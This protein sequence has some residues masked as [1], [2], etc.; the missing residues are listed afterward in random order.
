MDFRW[1]LTVWEICWKC[2]W[3]YLLF[4][5]LK[6]MNTQHLCSRLPQPLSL[7]GQDCWWRFPASSWRKICEFIMILWVLPQ[8]HVWLLHW[9]SEGL[10]SQTRTKSTF[11]SSALLF[12][13]CIV[14]IPS[15]IM[16]SKVCHLLYQGVHL[17]LLH[18]GTDHWW[19]LMV[20]L[21]QWW[22]TSHSITLMTAVLSN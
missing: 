19:S 18:L 8:T 4:K 7:P 3:Y 10:S 20:R 13:E 1:T 9:G 22:L 17:C 12:C 11:F 6:Q 2:W 16:F 14:F 15:L 5:V 21:H